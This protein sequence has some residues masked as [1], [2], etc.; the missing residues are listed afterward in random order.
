MKKLLVMLLVLA[1]AFSFAACDTSENIEGEII[2][3]GDA[4]PTATAT[5]APTDKGGI[6]TGTTSEFRYVNGFIGI[7]CTL[8]SDWTFKTD[9][10][11]KELNQQ[12][13]DMSGLDYSEA[14]ENA[15]LVYGMVATYKNNMDT[16]SVT[17]EK[18][19]GVGL[20]ITESDYL[21]ST[22]QTIKE[23][24][25]NMGLTNLQVEL[26]EATI[27]GEKHP[28]L[29]VEGDFN[30]VKMYEKL[31]VIKCDGYMASITVCTWME[32]TCD[33]ILAKFTKL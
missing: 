12:A 10:E 16:V 14:L 20:L 23:P 6:S 13:M 11:I 5:A 15:T 31:A 21:A 4:T 33:D 3:G 32:N 17:L 8:D 25:E 2:P 19:S 18:L 26:G 9:A 22:Q 7:T 1:M 28:V 24:L 30:G 29:F 27:A